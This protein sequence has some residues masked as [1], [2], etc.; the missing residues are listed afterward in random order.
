MIKIGDSVRVLVDDRADLT[1]GKTYTIT[2]TGTNGG[3]CVV[4]DV[5]EDNWTLFDEHL[6]YEVVRSD[7]VDALLRWKEA[8][9]ARFPSLAEPET[10]DDAAARFADKAI[11]TG[12]YYDTFMEA[13]A[14]ARE[15]VR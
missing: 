14:W 11:D 9:I 1:K 12:A 7:E 10:D 8:A 3:V 2:D 4:D 6:Q 5:N 13:F 15:N